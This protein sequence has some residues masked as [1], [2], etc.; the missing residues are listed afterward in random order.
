[1]PYKRCPFLRGINMIKVEFG[2]FLW[3]RIIG[4]RW[5]WIGLNWFNRANGSFCLS[6]EMEKKEVD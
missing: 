5:F 2:G 4:C 6:K 1:M 3:L